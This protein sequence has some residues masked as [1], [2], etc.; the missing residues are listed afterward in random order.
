MLWPM[1]LKTYTADPARKAALIA[2]T[3]INPQYLYQIATGRRKAGPV[4]AGRIA[5]ATDNE[6]SREELRPDY[7]GNAK[8][9]A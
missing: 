4:L 1:D 3:G 7:F 2:R 5:E 8:S 9:A 6:V